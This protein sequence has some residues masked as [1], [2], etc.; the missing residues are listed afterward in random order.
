MVPKSLRQKVLVS[1]HARIYKTKELTNRGVPGTCFWKEASALKQY[2]VL[3]ESGSKYS[4]KY[5]FLAFP[6]LGCWVS[7]HLYSQISGSYGRA[8]AK[9]L[10]IM[11]EAV[12]YGR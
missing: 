11:C 10:R 9:I 1:C 12:P 7:T 3:P 4:L 2:S 5:T 6:F 8:G